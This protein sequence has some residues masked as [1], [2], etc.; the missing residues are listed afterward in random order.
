VP[1]AVPKAA[2]TTAAA[3]VARPAAA[4]RPS[5]PSAAAVSVLDQGL[6]IAAVVIAL[7][8]IGRLLT[9]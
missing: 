6:A 3:P 2:P 8:V 5:A 1:V 7:A 4:P 9:L